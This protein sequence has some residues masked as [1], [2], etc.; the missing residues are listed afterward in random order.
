MNTAYE[1]IDKH[2]MPKDPGELCAV[3]LYGSLPTSRGN[4]KFI[5]VCYD[6]FTKHVK[7][8]ALRSAT[9]KSC[10]NK[11]LNHYCRNVIK[12]KVV[13]SDNGSQFRPPAWTKRLKEQGICAKFTPIR[14][15]ESN[16]SERVMRELSKFFRIYCQ[17]NHKKWVELLPSIEEWL[18]KT[19]A[20]A[21][22]FSP[23]ELMFGCHKQ[24]LFNK[25]LPETKIKV[26]NEEEWDTKLKSAWI[27]MKKKIEERERRRIRGNKK[28]NP[29]L[30][31]QVLVKAQNQS[32]AA[33]GQID[34]FM[35]VYQGPY[36][37]RNELPH[38]AYEIVDGNGKVK[39]VFNKKQLKPYRT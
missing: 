21:T 15:P 32:D 23:V 17:E 31:D 2:H 39:G 10:L 4:V 27:R 26:G 36:V 37:I 1:V 9:T 14:H 3:D 19:I 18:N 22:G 29:Q 30:G 28:W 13:L 24:S 20:S 7:L 11:L 8:Y 25:L 35:P 12:P 34:K 33:K 16:P 6:M 38:S 5:F